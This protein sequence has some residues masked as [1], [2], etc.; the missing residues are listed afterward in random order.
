[1]STVIYGK[2]VEL[3]TMGKTLRKTCLIM[4]PIT[5]KTNQG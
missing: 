5:N 3:N 4:P 2:L 1:M